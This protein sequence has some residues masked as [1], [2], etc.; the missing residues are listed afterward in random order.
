NLFRFCRNN[1]VN[2]IDDDGRQDDNAHELLKINFHE[3]VQNKILIRARHDQEEAEKVLA[4]R[5]NLRGQEL[6]ESL[7]KIVSYLED[8]PRSINVRYEDIKNYTDDYVKNTFATGKRLSDPSY[9]HD[10]IHRNRELIHFANASVDLKRHYDLSDS[11]SIEVSSA[12][13][14]PVHGS[15]QMQSMEHL[16]GG[17][18]DAD[19][20]AYGL[21]AFFLTE[22]PLGHLTYTSRD[23]MDLFAQSKYEDDGFLQNQMAAMVNMYPL[24]RYASSGQLDYFK[25]VAIDGKSNED[26]MKPYI[27]WHSH[28]RLHFG[29]DVNELNISKKEKGLRTR[30]NG[31][32]T[33]VN[34]FVSK[35]RI[36]TNTI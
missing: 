23:S 17:V 30:I 34:T 21:S 36:T 3:N 19:P 25:N 28:A 6:G 32:D 1:P 10:R 7:T 33:A 11:G 24:I 5:F 20:K 29:Q 14:H 15:I 35:H 9:V 13:A 18:P 2:V 4:E 26:P 22:R 8:A 27:E 12:S 16:Q 31:T